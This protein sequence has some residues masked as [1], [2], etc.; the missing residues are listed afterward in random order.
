MNRQRQSQMSLSFL[1]RHSNAILSVVLLFVIG[2]VFRL[3]WN[4]SAHFELV[5][6]RAQLADQSLQIEQ[7]LAQTKKANTT[8]DV[9]CVN[10]NVNS[11]VS[12]VAAPV[13]TPAPPPPP[14]P[15]VLC[16]DEKNF[17]EIALRCGTDKVRDHAYQYAYQ[18]YLGPM[19]LPGTAPFSMI[20]IGFA[21]GRGACV[22]REMLA[23]ADQHSTENGCSAESRATLDVN[24]ILTAPLFDVMVKE[25]RLHCGDGSDGEFMA[26]ILRSFKHPLTVVVDDGAHG[27]KQMAGSFSYLFPRIAPRG[28][29]FMEDL[30]ESYRVGKVGFV[31]KFV[32]PLSEDI[33][34]KAGDS[35]V[36]NPSLMNLPLL[37]KY[38][39][40]VHCYQH[41]CIFERNDVA[42]LDP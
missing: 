38:L 2:F 10:S 20:E 19:S 25:G 14:P 8:V 31:P 32:R 21:T 1:R 35:A 29:F 17:T 26:P 39:R 24:W 36:D 41:L 7:L 28:L 12:V 13:A 30:A 40:S 22:W 42:P 34:F 15:L 23:Q 3:A 16:K 4:D 27:A 9:K 5:R 11:V 6:L 37:S 33:H 18:R